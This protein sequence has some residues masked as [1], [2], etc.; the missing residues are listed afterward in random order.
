MDKLEDI[1]TAFTRRAGRKEF[2]T[3]KYLVYLQYSALLGKDDE[4]T[5][6]LVRYG[7]D[8]VYSKLRWLDK[9]VSL[10][11]ACSMNPDYIQKILDRVACDVLFSEYEE[12]GSNLN[13]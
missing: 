2:P 10:E 7:F 8:T 9:V 11:I 13:T 3:I 4:L 6:S 12:I 1:N 5:D